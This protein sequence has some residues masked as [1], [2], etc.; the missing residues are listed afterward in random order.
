VPWSTW[1]IPSTAIFAAIFIVTVSAQIKAKRF[2]PLLYWTT[3]I[4]TTAK[5]FN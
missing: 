2:H 5:H 3:I 4:A 1:S